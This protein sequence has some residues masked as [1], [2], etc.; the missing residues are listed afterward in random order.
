LKD[1]TPVYRVGHA[2]ILPV[3]LNGK[4]RKLFLLDTGAW[5]TIISPEAAREV[6]TVRPDD[7]HHPTGLNG[8][9]GNVYS[10]DEVAFRFANVSQKLKDVLSIDTARISQR[11]GMEIAGFLGANTLEQFILHIDYRDGLVK[12][13]SAAKA[14]H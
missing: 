11:S 8:A 13:D 9:V 14:G 6:T 7:R 1:Y 10:A 5:T 12:F 3:T 4:M 2:L